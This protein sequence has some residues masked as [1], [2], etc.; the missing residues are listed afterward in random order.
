VGVFV[1]FVAFLMHVVEDEIIIF[2]VEMMQYFIDNCYGVFVAFIWYTCI[3]ALCVIIA[4]CF[5]VFLAPAATGGGIAEIMGIL[6][7]INYKDVISMPTFFT[8][9]IGTVF[10]V[11]GGLCIGKEGPLLHIGAI[12]GVLICYLPFDIF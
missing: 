9:I 5:T 1:G 12:S 2:K 4:A 11:S 8:K 3:S 7:G 6:N 10:A